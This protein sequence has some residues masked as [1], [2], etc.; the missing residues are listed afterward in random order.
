MNER[1]KMPEGH[2]DTSSR[3]SPS[4][5]DALILVFAAIEA[6]AMRRRSR[7]RRSRSPKLP[8][9]GNVV[10]TMFH[11]PLVAHV[12]RGRQWRATIAQNGAGGDQDRRGHN[13]ASHQ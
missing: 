4:N 3:S 6:I 5:S 7:S 1:R 9:V 2:R 10:D 13:E 12:D 8:S 11:E